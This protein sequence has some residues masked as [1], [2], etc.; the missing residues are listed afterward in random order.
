[1]IATLSI[2]GSVNTDV[3][4]FYI[5][6]ILA[7]QMW[8]GAIFMMDNLSVHYASVVQ[9]AIEAVGTKVVFLPISFSYRCDRKLRPSCYLFDGLLIIFGNFLKGINKMKRIRIIFFL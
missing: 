1:M 7:P 3:F 6:E 5:Q 4:L 2:V 8:A 9:E